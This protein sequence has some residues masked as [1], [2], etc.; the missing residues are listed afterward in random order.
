MAKIAP[1]IL[2][3][4]FANLGDEVKD[5]CSGGA[6]YVHVDIMDGAFVPN[7]SFGSAVMKSLNR[8]T[9]IPYDVHL[10]IENPDNHLEDF[11]TDRTEFI[12]VHYEAC[13][14]IHRT[15][16]HI[17]EAGVKAGVSI[18]PGTSVNSLEAILPFV[19]LVLVM[20]VN[21]GFGGQSF[22]MESIDKVKKLAEKRKN[23]G[24][25]FMIEVDGGV[26]KNNCRVLKDAGCDILVAG[27]AIFKNKDRKEA[28][29]AL[30]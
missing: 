16:S 24:Y 2:A 5:I 11:I 19:D 29:N 6:D 15:L 8:Y 21:P 13:N 10:M 22:I 26:N 27:S 14:H 4:D 7:I 17:R 23:R 9:S 30:K 3:A 18:N 1:S 28:I 20:S 12:T 25:N